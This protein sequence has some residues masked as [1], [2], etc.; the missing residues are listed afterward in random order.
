MFVITMC[1]LAFVGAIL[2]AMGRRTVVAGHFVWV[3]SDLGLFYHNLSIG[4]N[5]QAALFFVFFCISLTGVI[6]WRFYEK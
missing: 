2:T 4:E 6:R 1:I 3:I 5:A